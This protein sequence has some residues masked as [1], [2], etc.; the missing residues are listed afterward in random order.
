M[1]RDIHDDPDTGKTM[2]PS[3]AQYR[4]INMA[5]LFL[6]LLV[7]ACGGQPAG[8]A[9]LPTPTTLYLVT[10]PPD[11]TATVTPFQPFSGTDTPG[12]PTLSTDTPQPPTVTFDPNALLL[13]ESSTQQ[14]INAPP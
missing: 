6:L 5:C 3:S 12:I 4:I 10:V 1:T 11:A 7:S 13:P 14:S 8:S 2:N 9:P